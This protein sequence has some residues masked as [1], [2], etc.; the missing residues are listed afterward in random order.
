MYCAIWKE[1]C[2]AHISGISTGSCAQKWDIMKGRC[3]KV[4]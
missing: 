1:E 2:S 3:T 4:G